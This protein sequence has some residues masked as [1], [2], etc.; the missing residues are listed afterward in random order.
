MHLVI[1]AAA[2]L[3]IGIVSLWDDGQMFRKSRITIK[4]LNT[5]HNIPEIEFVLLISNLEFLTL[6]RWPAWQFSID[7]VI[8]FIESPK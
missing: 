5:L 7:D 8:E 6:K 4:G 2:A 3:V 1:D